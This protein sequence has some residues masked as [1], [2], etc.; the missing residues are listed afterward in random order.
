MAKAPTTNETPEAPAPKKKRPTPEQLAKIH[1]GGSYVFNAA[2]GQ[3][4]QTRK[5]AAEEV[6]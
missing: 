1:K 3:L 6:K 4:V 2:T 5:P